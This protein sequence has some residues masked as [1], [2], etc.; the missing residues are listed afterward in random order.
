MAHA[1]HTSINEA[2]T[3]TKAMKRGDSWRLWKEA[4]KSKY[5]NLINNKT[6]ELVPLP[7]GR[8]SIGCKWIFKVKYNADGSVECYKA[9]LG[10]WD[11]CKKKVKTTLRPLLQLQR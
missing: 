9:R 10:H 5:Q 11:T 8:K 1:F 3:I 2:L 6:W 7:K 4:M